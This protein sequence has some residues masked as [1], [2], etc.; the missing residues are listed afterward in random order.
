MTQKTRDLLPFLQQSVLVA[1]WTHPGLIKIV[2]LFFVLIIE[3]L[4]EDLASF[5]CR[6]HRQES[7]PSSDMRLFNILEKFQI[8]CQLLTIE[9][10]LLLFPFSFRLPYPTPWL[11]LGFFGP[12]TNGI[13]SL[14][15]F[16][17][18]FCRM[19]PECITLPPRRRKVKRQRN[20]EVI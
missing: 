4:R 11:L 9:L 14:V 2:G 3:S 17:N 7:L 8:V 1:P 10:N 6:F 15:H 12:E 18:R 16:E 13:L 5:Y 19:F 20:L